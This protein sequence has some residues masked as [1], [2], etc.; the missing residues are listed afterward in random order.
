MA[1]I[2]VTPR[3]RPWRRTIEAPTLAALGATVVGVVLRV[4]ALRSTALGAFNGD[5]AVTGVMVRRI[6]AGQ[7]HYVFFAGQQYNG[8]LEQYLQA[9]MYWLFRLPQ[10]P[11]TLRY[12]QIALTAAA[13][14]LV[15]LVGCRLLA[16]PWA[17]VVAAVLFA[18]G[19]YWTLARGIGTFGAYPS[20]IVVGLVGLYCALRVGEPGRSGMFAAAGLGF[21]AGLIAWLG[22]SGVEL[23]IPAGFLA[24]PYLFRRW[25]LWMAAVPGLVVGMLPLLVWSFRNQTFALFDAGP[26]IAPSTVWQRLRNLFDPVVREFIGVAWT[27]GSPGWPLVLQYL[28]VA[29]LG[30]G[31][32][33]AVVRRRAGI[34]QMLRFRKA[35]WTPFDALLLSVPVVVVIY[36]AS[37]WA[38]VSAEPR[39]LFS[40][41]PVLVWCLAAAWPQRP[42][43]ARAVAVIAGAAVFAATSVTMLANRPY[44]PAAHSLADVDAASRYLRSSGQG[45][46]YADY[47]TA[48]PLL[49]IGGGDIAVAPL[50][51]GRTKFPAVTASVD[52]ADDFFYAA[53]GPSST[54]KFGAAWL[55][56]V[57]RAHQVTFHE[58][59][60]GR[61]VVLDQL[62]PA[63]KPWELGIGTPPSQ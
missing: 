7:N 17:A 52:Q 29:G 37:K 22:L 4:W 54:A 47:W 59:R 24:A 35:G 31:Y 51:A 48:M 20:L 27:N 26:P 44:V 13:T 6:L 49:Y 57:L 10:N 16:R 8:S 39:Y 53:T 18:F 14:W 23:L 56:N 46:G 50:S 63:L 42:S 12:P 55:K 32:I 1:E 36:G 58:V 60:F 2:V 43:V 15:Y 28:A 11:V 3:P 34:L 5:E 25:Q 33:V 45:F 19:P 30:L 61:V 41:S 38:W 62:E 9:G 40:F 21:S